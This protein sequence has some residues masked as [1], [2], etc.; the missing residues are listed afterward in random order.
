MKKLLV[1][2]LLIY[3]VSCSHFDSSA[4]TGTYERIWRHEAGTLQETIVITPSPRGGREFEIRRS[5]HHLDSGG[6]AQ[7]KLPTVRKFHG[8]YDPSQHMMDL[9]TDGLRYYFNLEKGTLQAGD[10]TYY[11]QP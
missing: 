2:L 1:M 8:V 6:T 3:T 9:G 7:R 5:A 10:N 4:I 11:K